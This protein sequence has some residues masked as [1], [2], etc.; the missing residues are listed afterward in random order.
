MNEGVQSMRPAES[1]S[2]QISIARNIQSTETV[3][4]NQFNSHLNMEKNGRVLRQQSI[5][6]DE[7]E[8]IDEKT[9]GTI[10]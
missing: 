9:D 2:I 4:T 3:V 10:K 8:K 1:T 7:E 6:S 5:L